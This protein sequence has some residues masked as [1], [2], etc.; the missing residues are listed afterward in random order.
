MWTVSQTHHRTQFLE[1]QIH[2]QIKI[3]INVKIV[4][5]N[6]LYIIKYQSNFNL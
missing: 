5:S 2:Y 1:E 4:Q 6:I 3:E